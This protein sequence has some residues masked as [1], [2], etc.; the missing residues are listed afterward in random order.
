MC[1][2]RNW[3]VRRLK[4]NW[5]ERFHHLQM[6][7]MTPSVAASQPSRRG[8]LARGLHVDVILPIE[9]RPQKN[10]IVHDRVEPLSGLRRSAEPSFLSGTCHNGESRSRSGT[11]ERPGGVTGGDGGEAGLRRGGVRGT[12]DGLCQGGIGAGARISQRSFYVLAARQSVTH[13]SC[14]MGPALRL[15]PLYHPRHQL[16]IL[17]LYIVRRELLH[18]P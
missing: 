16:T 10:N 9:T 17:L 14:Q 13:S 5:P 3:V 2:P 11:L 12:A 4:T 7:C 8:A 1:W 15:M 18:F 6:K